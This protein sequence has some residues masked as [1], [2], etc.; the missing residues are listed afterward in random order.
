MLTAVLLD[1][2][3]HDSIAEQLKKL[4]ALIPELLV[5]QFTRGMF[6]LE[7]FMD[8]A[9]RLNRVVHRHAG[10]QCV[11]SGRGE[12]PV[13]FGCYVACVHRLSRYAVSDRAAMKVAKNKSALSAIW[14]ST[15]SYRS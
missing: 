8:D 15:L 1:V 9:Q 12:S 3:R 13:Q 6:G 5:G 11:Y 7:C 2:V 10:H 4:P 14:I